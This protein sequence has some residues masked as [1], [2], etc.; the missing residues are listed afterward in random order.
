MNGAL[1]SP[2]LTPEKS[3]LTKE[4]STET[5]HESSYDTQNTKV[6]IVEA[7]MT[8]PE[9]SGQLPSEAGS[10]LSREEKQRIKAL[11]KEEVKQKKLEEKRSK[12]LQKEREK[13]EK[14]MA[15][16]ELRRKKEQEKIEREQ[17]REQEKQER[18]L[19]REQERKEK[20]RKR[21]QE[22]VEREQKKEQEKRK[23]QL[24][25]EEKEKDRLEK[26]RKVL[27]EKERKEELKKK[28]Q[29]DRS[30][31]KI[32]NFFQIGAVPLSQASDS[33]P[34]KDNAPSSVY[35]ERFL[36]FFKKDNVELAVDSQL[37]KDS[38][39]Q[40]ISQYDSLILSS[41]VSFTDL[42]ASE[43]TTRSFNSKRYTT[44][45]EIVNALNSSEVTESQIYSM[46]GN[47]S[48]I[49][50]LHFYENARPPY[51]GTWC[52]EEHQSVK[53]TD[54]LNTDG[55]GMD[56]DYDSDLEWNGEEEG[57]GEDIDNEEED[58]EDEEDVEED[59]MDDFVDTNESRRK[60]PKFL[61]PLVSV[62]KWNDGTNDAVFADMRYE[63][64]TKNLIFPINPLKN[65]WEKEGG[66]KKAQEK[67]QQIPTVIADGETKEQPKQ[68]NTL[69][70]HKPVITDQAVVQELVLFIE[71]N[72]DF[73]IGT[74]VELCQ[75]KFKS[76]TKSLIK[77]TVQQVASYDKK[78]GKWNIKGEYKANSN[79][80]QQKSAAA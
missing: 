56:Y 46:L 35:D 39:A 54:P 29:E 60:K 5:V 66:S 67:S 26:K 23:R 15:R 79:D 2:M 78:A 16:E 80:I 65:Y 44:P 76:F 7:K 41:K 30:Q 3:A 6:D 10:L 59:E 61:G 74:L 45:L 27:E 25:R 49:K 69:T 42:F 53:L 51:I 55:T 8:T 11:E 17:K 1:N 68:V 19:K 48:P 34:S 12:E 52:S 47:L 63:N 71:Q 4:Q 13:L 64:L 57:E 37:G 77:H 58:E 38:L 72:N 28:A 24:E 22:K 9:S 21:E 62:N 75:K 18:E 14:E 43:S 36:P 70:P 40:A 32:S 20:E 73:T 31:M 33:N 50:Y